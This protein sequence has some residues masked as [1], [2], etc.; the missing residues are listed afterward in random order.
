[1]R[2]LDEDMLDFSLPIYLQDDID[3]TYIMTRENELAQVMK[4]NCFE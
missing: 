3:K 4:G 2:K 1:M